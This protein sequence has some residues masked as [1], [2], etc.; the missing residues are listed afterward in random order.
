MK[1]SRDFQKLQQVV[2]KYIDEERIIPE[3]ELYELMFIYVKKIRRQR[4]EADKLAEIIEMK[5][6][7][8]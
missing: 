1:K 3:G 5:I 4:K 7:N 2:T 6:L 8:N